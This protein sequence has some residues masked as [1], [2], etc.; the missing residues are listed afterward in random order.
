MQKSTGQSST[1]GFT[2]LDVGKSDLH[3][4]FHFNWDCSTTTVPHPSHP[5]Q[6]IITGLNTQTNVGVLQE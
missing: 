3:T 6:N 5:I 4:L 1:E 2:C